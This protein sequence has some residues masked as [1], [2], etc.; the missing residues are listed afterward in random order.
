L[1]V[2]GDQKKKV[3]QN[4]NPNTRSG[5]SLGVSPPPIDVLLGSLKQQAFPNA[6]PRPADVPLGSTYQQDNNMDSHEFMEF[7]ENIQGITEH[8][9]RVLSSLEQEMSSNGGNAGSPAIRELQQDVEADIYDANAGNI[10]NVTCAQPDPLFF[11]SAITTIEKEIRH[12]AYNQKSK[13]CP[14]TANAELIHFIV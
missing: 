5:A 14:P 2:C 13:V 4:T 12:Y 10:S 8:L 1:D 7:E 9:N 11:F 3:G 6:I